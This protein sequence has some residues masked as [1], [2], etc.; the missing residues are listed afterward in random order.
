[1]VEV[2]GGVPRVQPDGALKVLGGLVVDAQFVQAGSVVAVGCGV[3]GTQF[4]RP[5]Q[6]CRGPG[7]VARL[8]QRHAHLPV[9]LDAAGVTLYGLLEVGHRL[10]VLSLF[11]QVRALLVPGGRLLPPRLHRSPLVCALGKRGANLP[12]HGIVPRAGEAPAPTGRSG[13]PPYVS[14]A[15]ALPTTTV[16]AAMI[17]MYVYR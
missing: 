15:A 5:V 11:A 3:S 10:A 17:M 14:A 8:V 16:V 4:H 12:L 7:A 2:G 1:M 13:E 9:R 6:G